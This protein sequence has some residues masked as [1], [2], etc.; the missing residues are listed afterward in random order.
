MLHR[1]TSF[2]GI[3]GRKLMDLY[4]EGN[5]DN[6]EYFH[7][8]AADKALALQEQE[9]GFLRFI[10]T[11]FLQK[12]GNEYWVLEEEHTWVSA[13]R[14]YRISGELYY[15]EALETHP[16]FRRRGCA[17]RLLKGVIRELRRRGPFCLCD[18]VGK[19]N[20]PSIRT[21][22]KCGFEI[23]AQAGLNYLTG[24]TKENLYGMRYSNA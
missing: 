3:D 16:Q 18:C 24:E 14:L 6:V 19:R 21:H 23:S 7:P 15:I 2:D 8:D 1:I 17:E 12:A 9:E 10:R 13:L 20:E 11:D 5:L 4:R 22:L